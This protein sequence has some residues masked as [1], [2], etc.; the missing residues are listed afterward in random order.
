MPHSTPNSP[1]RHPSKA[2][3]LGNTHRYCSVG[4]SFP[5]RNSKH[6]FPYHSSEGGSFH[7][8]RRCEIRLASAEIDVQPS[9]GLHKYRKVFLLVLLF[10][11][12]GKIFL[13]IE[14]QADK[15]RAVAGKGDSTQWRIIMLRIFHRIIKPN[16]REKSLF[17]GDDILSRK[18]RL[19]CHENTD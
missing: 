17:P 13:S 10:K 18:Y 4:H 7:S 15:G 16:P 11:C 19:K 5:K 12:I 6:N 3:L 2:F 9:A 1:C 8:E 14:P